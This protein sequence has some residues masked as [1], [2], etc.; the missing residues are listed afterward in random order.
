MKITFLV[1]FL[2][3]WI[4]NPVSMS[5]AQSSE[6]PRIT[7]EEAQSILKAAEDR[8]RQDNWTVAIA[9]VDEGGHLL[10]FSRIIGTQLGSI[11]IALSKAK[12]SVFYKRPTKAFQDGLADANRSLLTIPHMSGFE[13]G[14]PIMDQGMVIGAIGVSGVTAHQDGIIARA[15]IQALGR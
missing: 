14:V 15:G 7:L 4:A 5:H 12:A 11:D 10:A 2:L 3:G 8:A 9:I 6:P 1:L 13:G